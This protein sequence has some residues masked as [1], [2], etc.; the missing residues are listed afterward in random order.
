MIHTKTK[1]ILS[2]QL[3]DLSRHNT[4]MPSLVLPT[5]TQQ[6][7]YYRGNYFQE[8]GSLSNVYPIPFCSVRSTESAVCSASTM[9]YLTDHGCGFNKDAHNGTFSSQQAETGTAAEGQQGGP[10]CLTMSDVVAV[11]TLIAICVM[12]GR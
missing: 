1:P 9:S 11:E 5:A 8:H 4:G 7:I 2:F 6:A 12:L 3:V 10:A